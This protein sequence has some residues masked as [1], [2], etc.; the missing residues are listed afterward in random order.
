MKS[1]IESFNKAKLYSN[2]GESYFSS[3]DDILASYIYL[4]QPIVFVEI[5]VRDGGGLEMW[6]DYLPDGSRII[7]IDNN[8]AAKYFE[9]D[10]Y[11]IFIGDQADEKFWSDFFL[12]VGN[13]DII[14]D[15][16]G[17]TNMQQ[18]KTLLSTINYINDGGML[19][20]EDTHASYL[21]AFSNPS[22]YSFIRYVY[23]L[24]DRINY[25]YEPLSSKNNYL[26]LPIYKISFF[27]SI[28]V[29]Y[30]D[31]K[32]SNLSKIIDNGGISMD[33]E[34]LRHKDETIDKLKVRFAYLKYIPL[35]KTLVSYF[36]RKKISL[37]YIKMKKYFK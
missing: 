12:K 30:K 24:V 29:L 11:E 36:I 15:D 10:Q 9:S 5:G 7:G 27:E 37:E 13:V 4:N 16:G 21:P 14:L 20:I 28:C 34:D 17:H 3:Y 19:I 6:K 8:S 32:K 25:R 31:I 33:H 22:K 35:V 1:S 23:N 26:D 18:L 2:K